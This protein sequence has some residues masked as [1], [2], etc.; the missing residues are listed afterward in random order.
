[1]QS[2][3]KTPALTV[4]G[5]LE[6]AQRL[7]AAATAPFPETTSYVQRFAGLFGTPG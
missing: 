2:M 6:T 1:M 4:P 7:E 5:A 3:I